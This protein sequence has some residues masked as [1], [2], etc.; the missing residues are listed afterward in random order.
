M[1]PKLFNLTITDTSCMCGVFIC[2]LCLTRLMLLFTRF[3][4]H[5]SHAFLLNVTAINICGLNA[6]VCLVCFSFYASCCDLMKNTW[7]TPQTKSTPETPYR[8]DVQLWIRGMHKVLYHS[9]RPEEAHSHT[10]WGEAIP[11]SVFY[12]QT[13][14]NRPLAAN[15]VTVI[16]VDTYR[17][18]FKTLSM[19]PSLHK[20]WGI[21][22]V[23]SSFFFFQLWHY[24]FVLVVCSELHIC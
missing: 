5:L 7:L 24:L 4:R 20:D 18:L 8:Q 15:E 22:H 3:C 14:L 10:H 23:N 2:C 6:A 11:V 12:Y 21:I 9:Q 1:P 16:L 13:R 17:E 19:F